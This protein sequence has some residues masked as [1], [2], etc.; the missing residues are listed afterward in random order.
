M[1]AASAWIH[2]LADI[3]TLSDL[4][5]LFSASALCV[6]AL[7]ACLNAL[8][9]PRLRPRHVSFSHVSVLIPARN[10]AAVIGATVESLLAQT[11]V[12]F[13]LIIL[14]DGSTDGTR[15]AALAAAKSDARLQ[16]IAGEP[17][18][19][20][21]L[22]KNWACQQLAAAAS[23]DPDGV[24]IF[25]DA[26]VTWQPGALAALLGELAR[27]NRLGWCPDLVTV[28]STQTTVTWGE[29]LV[30]PLMALVILSYLPYPL[31][32]YTLWSPFAAANGQCLAFRRRAY[33]ALGGHAAVRRSIVE[34]ISF[35]RA[36]KRSGRRLRMVDGG[37]LIGC[38]MYRSWAQVRDGYAKNILAGYGDS[39]IALGLATVFHYLVFFMPWVWFIIGYPTLSLIALGVGTRAL[40]AAVSRQRIIDAVF[41]PVSVLLMTLIAA[42]AVY[43]RVRYGGARWKG[44]TV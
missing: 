26:D 37:G 7:I 20:G 12:D 39:V 44:R 17:L 36:I 15:E 42:Q 16:V 24:L 3:V 40:T 19:E 32:E 30:V 23:A 31:V 10:E 11:G 6:I 1:G 4:L 25:A 43:W 9:F 35:A 13:E 14:D 22:G 18:P 21:W 28:W 27:P 2:H 41:M 33:N 34:D 8:T 5:I 29:R 38:R